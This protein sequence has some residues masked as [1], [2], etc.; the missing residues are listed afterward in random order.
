MLKAFEEAEKDVQAKAEELREIV[1]TYETAKNLA[2]K[3]KGVEVDIS[4]QLQ[5]YKK[6]CWVRRWPRF[7]FRRRS[8]PKERSARSGRGWH[9]AR[10]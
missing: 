8:Q 3:I 5:E 10:F 4:L 1:D 2:D 6:V 9:L 7:R